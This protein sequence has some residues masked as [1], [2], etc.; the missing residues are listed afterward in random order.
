MNSGNHRKKTGPARS[1]DRT[2]RVLFTCI[3]RRV[4]LV[5]AFRAAAERLHIGLEIHGADSSE[6][7]PALNFVDR[8]H[9]LPA[10]S[11][12]RYYRVLSDIVRSQ[13]ISMLVPLIDTE[14]P[15]LA[16]TRDRLAKLG[17]IAVVSSPQV[18]AT[19]RD[20]LATYD[21]LTNGGIDTPATWPWLTAIRFRRHH[22]PYF[23]K[24][25]AGSAAMGNYMVKTREGLRVFGR[26]VKD[27]IVQEFITGDE[28]TVDVYCGF[29]GVPRC[30]VPRLRLE[31]RG[32]EVTKALTVDEPEI[33]STAMRVA[34]VLGGC[35]G[36]I[37]VQCMKM[38]SGRVQVIEINPRFGGGVPLAI[39]AGADFP[40]WLMED[41][42][43][44]SSTASD[45]YERG[46][47]ML[48]F[49]ESVFVMNSRVHETNTMK[50]KRRIGQLS[51]SQS[52]V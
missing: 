37:T 41:Y 21:M 3:G 17:C 38:K 52:L 14:L 39:R 50:K 27:P 6:L 34:E 46:L 8:T 29:D 24:P 11:S 35:R 13:R 42:L 1:A 26:R 45:A 44:I 43:G 16:A 9:L 51:L 18:V 12:P 49:D 33:R 15:F 31:V 10:I 7:A 40:G 5:R 47:L 20:K 4:E 48:R 23:L 22:F 25:R 19:C 32:G 2:I 36:V 30:A 28:Y